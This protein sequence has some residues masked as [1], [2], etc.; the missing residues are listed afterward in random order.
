VNGA[1]RSWIP[2]SAHPHRISL[3]IEGPE[4]FYLEPTFS[5]QSVDAAAERSLS[6][7]PVA[8]HSLRSEAGRT[9]LELLRP[10]G[11]EPEA[12]HVETTTPSFFRH[13]LVWDVAQGREDRRLG[14]AEIFRIAAPGLVEQLDVPVQGAVGDRLRLEIEDRDSPPL[15]HMALKAMLR[16]LGLVFS[17]SP[18]RDG[19]PE[20][21]LRFG[22]G[23]TSPPSYDLADLNRANGRGVEV[24]RILASLRQ[25]SALS[26]EVVR[27]GPVRPNPLFD[28]SPA[29]SFAM[30]PGSEVDP[31][32]YRRRRT[33]EVNPTSEGLSLVALDPEDAAAARSDLADVRV[34]DSTHRQWPYVL[35][36]AARKEWVELH[37]TPNKARNRTS[38]LQFDFPVSPVVI[39]RVEIDPDSRFFDRKYELVTA[40]RDG[41]ERI[42]AAGRL[43]RRVGAT[44]PIAID[45]SPQRLERIELQVEDGDDAP[46]VL[47]SARARASLPT[48]FLVAPA[49]SYTLLVGD[50]DADRPHY[51]VAEV[52]DVVLAVASVPAHMG[53][54]EAN[55]DYRAYLGLTSGDRGTR[56]SHEI[57]LWTTLLGGVAALA[58][59]TLRAVRRE[60]QGSESPTGN[61]PETK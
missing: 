46:L 20:A 26:S 38:R 14:E 5:F 39:D 29:L 43:V 48:L 42:L 4:D 36:S 32:F 19:T 59:L 13:A 51:Q 1:E 37:A 12:L 10:P 49:G 40:A 28:P 25:E 52:R 55:P 30:Q 22:G 21:V 9:V 7:V 54:S 15:D 17:L 3:L 45:F 31:R 34:V 57:L 53:P 2:L 24:D 6:V 56:L 16:P 8:V 18:A 33:V 50:P 23:R 11:L 60:G 61:G 35:E 27:L 58:L 41:G 44:E 47:R